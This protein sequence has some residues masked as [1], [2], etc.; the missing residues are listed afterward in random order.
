MYS[1]ASRYS[2]ANRSGT[3]LDSVSEFTPGTFLGRGPVRTMRGRARL[4]GLGFMDLLFPS[5]VAAP[6]YD[7]Y[8]DPAASGGF[9]WNK[10]VEGV[11][12]IYAAKTQA[13]LTKDLYE[14]NLQRAAKGLAPVPASAV[15]P[16]V[17]VGVSRDTQN[18]IL[19][20]ALGGAGILGLSYLLSHR[21]KRRR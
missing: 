19:M 17:Q 10:L 9:D 6:A 14:L 2:A 12:E 8:G 20:V 7:P 13:D 5:D 1:P 11:G 4:A 15:S 3:A 16:Q 18:T 21:G